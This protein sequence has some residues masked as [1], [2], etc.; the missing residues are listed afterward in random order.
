MFECS[1]LGR[2]LLVLPVGSG[3]VV[4]CRAALL[5]VDR[6]KLGAGIFEAFEEFAMLRPYGTLFVK[7][8]N[9]SQI[10]LYSIERKIDR[11]CTNQ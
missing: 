5:D 2:R 10:Q 4:V 9:I 1:M 3:M 6:I 11:R 7:L 8:P